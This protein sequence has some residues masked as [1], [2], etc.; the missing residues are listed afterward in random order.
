MTRWTL[1]WKITQRGCGDLP[2][3][4]VSPVERGHQQHSEQTRNLVSRRDYV[5]PGFDN[6]VLEYMV[7]VEGD[8]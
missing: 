8:A 4:V 7:D 1:S 5:G 3:V 2:G 6:E